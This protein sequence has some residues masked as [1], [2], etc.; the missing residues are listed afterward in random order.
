MLRP[1]SFRALLSPRLIPQDFSS[2]RRNRPQGRTPGTRHLGA[3]HLWAGLS[4]IPLFH[5]KGRAAMRAYPNLHPLVARH[6]G[7][8]MMYAPPLRPAHSMVTPIRPLVVRCTHNF[9][10]AMLYCSNLR[11]RL[12]WRFI[13]D[14][15]QGLSV[16]RSINNHDCIIINEFN[17]PQI[18]I[19]IDH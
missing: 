11:M 6:L 13:M 9:A 7:I 2:L 1:S 3:V 17:R 19:K 14:I 15:A 8:R 18:F 12:R 10:G 16:S 5:S 4:S